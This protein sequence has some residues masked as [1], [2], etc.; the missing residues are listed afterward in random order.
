MIWL[1]CR[2]VRLTTLKELAT[3]PMPSVTAL[4]D[5][6]DRAFMIL[7]YCG[8]WFRATSTTEPT[9]KSTS[10]GLRAA[11]GPFK[12]PS[13]VI[14]LLLALLLRPRVSVT[15]ERERF[16][17]FCLALS[18]EAKRSEVSGGFAGPRGRAT[19]LSLSLSS[20]P[21]SA[22][23]GS[24]EALLLPRCLLLVRLPPKK[25]RHIDCHRE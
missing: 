21:C 24:V 23:S 3:L 2:M 22:G 12:H 9:P 14:L 15:A 25:R 18:R 19:G 20:L 16:F 17:R 11:T 1:A 4:R 8:I 7:Q 13:E 10:G 6:A 5:S